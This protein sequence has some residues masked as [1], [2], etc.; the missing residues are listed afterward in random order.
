MILVEYEYSKLKIT[1]RLYSI[2]VSFIIN[3]SFYDLIVLTV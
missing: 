1:D 2:F 3:G